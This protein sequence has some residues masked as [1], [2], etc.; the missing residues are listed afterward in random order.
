M[1]QRCRRSSFSNPASLPWLGIGERTVDT[2]RLADVLEAKAGRE[3]GRCVTVLERSTGCVIGVAALL[4]P[5]PVDGIPW[6][7]VLALAA[8]HQNLGLGTE[9]A[10]GLEGLL[11]RAGWSEVRLSVLADNPRALR[12]WQRLGYGSLPAPG[13][14][15]TDRPAG[16]SRWRRP[17][18]P[19]VGPAANTPDEPPPLVGYKNLISQPRRVLVVEHRAMGQ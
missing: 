15:T 6:I 9:A 8:D 1:Y 19:P 7:S 18:R 14:R 2:G 11:A 12:F 17:S 13:A 16:P 3:H 10:L 4:V 5:N